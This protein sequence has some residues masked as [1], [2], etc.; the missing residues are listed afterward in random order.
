MRG[1]VGIATR[2]ERLAVRRSGDVKKLTAETRE[3]RLRV[4]NMRGDIHAG[5]IT[6][7][8]QRI[9]TRHKKN[10]NKTFRVPGWT[11]VDLVRDAESPRIPAT[12]RHHACALHSGKRFDQCVCYRKTGKKLMN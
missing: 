1:G 8:A 11:F 6:Q 5:S 2:E 7:R 4:G 10:C 12:R 9:A 3:Y